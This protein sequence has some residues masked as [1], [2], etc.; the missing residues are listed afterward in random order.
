[1]NI[2][3]T[4]AVV[5]VPPLADGG[6]SHSSQ[7]QAQASLQ[8]APADPGAVVQAP[9]AQAPKPVAEAPA[10][11]AVA[12]T[13]QVAVDPETSQVTV[14]IVDGATRDVILKIPFEDAVAMA[15]TQGNGAGLLVNA[16]A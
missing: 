11:S 7:R 8:P 15:Q 5:V 4:G 13:F 9:G 1:M 3:L 10:A 6:A 12:G 2:Q 16:K 14:Q